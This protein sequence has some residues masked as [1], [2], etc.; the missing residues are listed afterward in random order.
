MTLNVISKQK[1]GSIEAGDKI[2]ETRYS[3]ASGPRFPRF[4]RFAQ[5]QE[6]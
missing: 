1:E 5:E 3:P 6:N 2:E 4:A